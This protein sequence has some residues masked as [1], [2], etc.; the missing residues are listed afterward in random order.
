MKKKCPLCNKLIEVDDKP[1]S[2]IVE[3]KCPKCDGNLVLFSKH[4]IRIEGKNHIRVKCSS[5]EKF[6]LHEISR[7]F[8][9]SFQILS[10]LH[11]NCPM[12]STPIVI[13]GILQNNGQESF[14]YADIDT[15]AVFPSAYYVIAV[16]QPFNR[17]SR[18]QFP[19]ISA[20]KLELKKLLDLP[21]DTI[22]REMKRHD[23]YKTVSESIHSYIVSNLEEAEKI[24]PTDFS[25]MYASCNLLAKTEKRGSFL[26]LIETLISLTNLVK[27][28]CGKAAITDSVIRDL[29]KIPSEIPYKW[30]DDLRTWQSFP[31]YNIFSSF[32]NAPVFMDFGNLSGF[33]A[34]RHLYRPCNET[35]ITQNFK[36]DLWYIDFGCIHPVKII[37]Y[38]TRNMVKPDE[39]LN[40]LKNVGIPIFE[41]EKENIDWHNYED[42]FLALK[43]KEDALGF[44]AGRSIRHALGDE[45]LAW[46]N[47]RKAI[48]EKENYT[49]QICGYHTKETKYLHAHEVWETGPEPDVLRLTDIQLLCNRCHDCHHIGQF[50][51]RNPMS[52]EPYD[53]LIMHMAKVNRCAPEVVYA[54]HKY[55]MDQ[56]Q[57]KRSEELQTRT[58]RFRNAEHIVA[59]SESRT[60]RYVINHNVIN[61]EE[62]LV[63]LEKK[64]LAYNAK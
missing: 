60:V 31:P 20:A 41:L 8:S 47:T 48:L 4:K 46:K 27:D 34:Q 56:L 9:N 50:E 58:E 32:Y 62:L 2:S 35:D 38:A 19:N 14:L 18:K 44:P 59:V 45:S 23:D 55:R 63:A 21:D 12:C 39:V 40:V 3:I 61:R 37:D 43:L 10:H 42:Q 54:Y 28:V 52:T 26:C 36:D 29:D 64:G 16:K 53:K 6:F 11:Q 17:I 7:D 22:L 33:H 30:K 25:V 1:K 51:M 49:C 24:L 13:K 57:K 15:F 5:C